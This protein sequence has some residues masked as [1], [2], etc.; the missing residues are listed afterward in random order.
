MG[1]GR[2]SWRAGW[3]PE[4]S[5][6]AAAVGCPG[7]WPELLQRR[8]PPG[9]EDAEQG[10]GLGDCP[11]A[12]HPAAAVLSGWQRAEGAVD[13][14]AGWSSGEETAEELGSVTLKHTSTKAYNA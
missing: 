3:V 2:G 13:E 4:R 12:E 8:P 6:S 14:G 7:G 1:L 10:W 9:A 5:T 11:R